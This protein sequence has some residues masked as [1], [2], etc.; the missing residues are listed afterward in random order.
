MELSVIKYESNILRNWRKTASWPQGVVLSLSASGPVGYPWFPVINIFLFK[1]RLRPNRPAFFGDLW[2]FL[3]NFWGYL[4][5][6]WRF[7]E[8]F[9]GILEN[10]WQVLE[11]LN[12]VRKTSNLLNFVRRTSRFQIEVLKREVLR[13][14]WPINSLGGQISNQIWNLWPKLHILHCLFGLF[15]PF[16]SSSWKK[17][18]RKKTTRL[19]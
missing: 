17:E 5:N 4:E 1:T 19:Y 18:E 6:L 9:W 13:P 15:W 3:E 12:F 11:I 16:F 10:F 7:L 8:S 14:M 2:R